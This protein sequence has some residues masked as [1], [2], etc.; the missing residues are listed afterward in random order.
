MKKEMYNSKA[1]KR[2]NT[3]AF[4]NT[5]FGRVAEKYMGNA[6]VL[7]GPDARTSKALESRQFTQTNIYVPNP[8][9]YKEIR[10]VK[11]RNVFDMFLG[12]F[13]D[14]AIEEGIN[15]NSTWLDYCCNFDGNSD[16][17]PQDDIKKY[18]E[19][20]LHIEGAFAVTFCY[21]K[22]TKVHYTNEDFIRAENFIQQTAFDNDYVAIKQTHRSYTGMFFILYEIHR[23]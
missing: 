23:L 10:K 21:R 11:R 9:S 15:F 18:F 19:S 13:L 4:C 22:G 3:K 7:D 14:M 12:E 17:K 8:Y 20:E 16:M 5:L 2:D 6:L 1:K